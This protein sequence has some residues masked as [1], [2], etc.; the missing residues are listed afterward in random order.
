MIARY[1]RPEMSSLWSEEF[2]Y[3][4]WLKIELLAFEK[5]AEL[6]T[7]PLQAYQEAKIKAAFNIER[8]KEIEEEVKHDVIAFLTNVAENVGPSARFFHRGL[9]SSDV[10]D[11]ALAYQLVKSSEIITRGLDEL[12]DVLKERAY[13]HK[14][15]PCVGRSHGIHAEPT[16]FGLKLASW[17][18]EIKRQKARF[19]SAVDDIR[20]GKLAGAVGTYASVSPEVE[21]HVLSGMGLVPE[22]VP[23]Q[24]VHRD[25]HAA[26]FSALAQMGSS[27]ERFVVEIRHLQRTEVREAEESFSG[28]QKGSS[29]M[30]HKKNPILSENL[31]GLAR[32]LRGYALSAAENVALWHERDIS[33]SSVE[34]VI[35]PDACVLTDF[36][37]ARFTAMMRSLEINPQRMQANLDLTGGLVFSGSLLLSLVDNGVT[38]ED[39]YRLVQKH[40]LAAWEGG[41]SFESRIRNEKEI[42]SILSQKEISE[43]FGMERHLAR[44]DLIFE[45]TFI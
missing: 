22:T 4:T 37:L 8:I 45:R 11:T 5:M 32:L 6:G 3:K 12:L 26:F 14:F 9:T 34:R 36:M 29:A 17:Y 42:S 25:R 44:V 30:P 23:S 10:L 21:K 15:T 35:A 40:A 2:K 24:I 27:I 1:S 39:A 19:I 18:A 28:G 31:T 7:V 20:A 33:H 41:A 16:S 13:Q 38:R 43:V